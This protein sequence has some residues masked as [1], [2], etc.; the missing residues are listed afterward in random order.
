MLDS[1]E[2]ICESSSKIK[3]DMMNTLVQESKIPKNPRTK[4]QDWL[5]QNIK[6]LGSQLKK[7]LYNKI[8]GFENWC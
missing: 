7:Q 8:L 1:L 4:F 5:S 6:T 3:K 2:M